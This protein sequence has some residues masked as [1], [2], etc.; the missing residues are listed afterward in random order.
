M[1]PKW[2]FSL[3]T[4][5]GADFA[6]AFDRG[7]LGTIFAIYG[8]MVAVGEWND[9]AI[10]HLRRVAIFS[11]FRRASGWPL[12]RIEKWPDT[13]SQNGRYLVVGADGRVL[14]SGKELEHVMRYFERRFFRVIA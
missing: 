1:T 6:I 7:E 12:F 13:A 4:D 14:R 3:R 2:H 8:R 5:G 9:Y 10:S 11:I